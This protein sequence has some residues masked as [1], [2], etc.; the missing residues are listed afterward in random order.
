MIYL[1]R[2]GMSVRECASLVEQMPSI[3]VTINWLTILLILQG[4]A[5]NFSSTMFSSVIASDKLK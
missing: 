3:S 1:K 4:V 5:H 2:V